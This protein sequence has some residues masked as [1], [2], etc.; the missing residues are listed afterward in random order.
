M[1]PLFVHFS[2]SIWIEVVIDFSCSSTIDCMTHQGIIVNATVHL[3]CS[4]TS[5]LVEKVALY[6]TN[7]FSEWEWVGILV[8][9]PS[10]HNFDWVTLHIPSYHYFLKY[11]CLMIWGLRD[12]KICGHLD[13]HPSSHYTATQAIVCEC[14]Q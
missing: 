6:I 9:D 3:I 10:S 2:R 5:V 13:L 7:Y 11:F 14:C 8:V 12:P 1:M 4:L